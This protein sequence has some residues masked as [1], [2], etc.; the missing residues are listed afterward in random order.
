MTFGSLFSGIGGFDLGFERAG[1]SCKWQVEIDKDCNRVLENQW[2]DVK[3]FRDI[4]SVKIEELE[5]ADVIS[6]GSPCQ[7]LS[8]AGRRKG[9]AGERSGLFYEAMRIVRESRPA[10]A[11]WENVP[12][13]FSSNA[14][15]DFVAVLREFRECG[16]RDIAWRVFDS[17][18]CGVAQQRRR[19]FVVADFRGERAGEILFESKGLCRHSPPRQETGQ[20]IAET[21]AF[22]AGNSGDSY[23]IGLREELT[24]PLRAGASGTNQVPTV[25]FCLTAH[26][27]MLNGESETFIAATLTSNGDAHS[28]FK[29]ANGLVVANRF[30]GYTGCSDDN[31]AQGNHLVGVIQHSSIGRK[32]DA[33]PQGKGWRD[34]GK[35]WTMDSRPQADVIASNK[36][37]V[38]RLTP[39]ECERLQNFPDDFTRWDK[40]GKEISD[41]ARY[42]ML[43]NAVTVSVAKWIG[44]RILRFGD[45]NDTQ[46]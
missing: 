37:G 15:L 22:S 20:G 23:G 35:A 45:G 44:E 9:L 7:D 11:V 21:F 10:F 30:N 33:G 19:V 1:L 18:Y 42:R 28:G 8:V 4:I 14:G 25:A 46:K 27:Q 32:N 39:R 40:D 43:G 36:F 5:Q 12:G 13:A 31:D 2:P 41:S 6:F 26:G 17:Q 38:R 16:A 24:P 29:D 34:N 3:R